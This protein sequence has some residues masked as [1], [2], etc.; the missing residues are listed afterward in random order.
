MKE[1]KVSDECARMIEWY[2]R[3]DWEGFRYECED[4]LDALD[5]LNQI[6]N[7]GRDSAEVARYAN[8]AHIAIDRLLQYYKLMKTL[9]YEHDDRRD[10]EVQVTQAE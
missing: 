2:R 9:A 8:D 7:A 10:G 1:V 5:G 4:I 3:D 6:I